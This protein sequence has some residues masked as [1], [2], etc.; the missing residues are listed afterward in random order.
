MF[1]TADYNGHDQGYLATV[2]AVRHLRGQKVPK[3]MILPTKVATKGNIDPWL[4]PP[5][6]RPVPNFDEVAAAQKQA[7]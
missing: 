1:A 4:L 5:E 2:A 7:T 6:E 3:E